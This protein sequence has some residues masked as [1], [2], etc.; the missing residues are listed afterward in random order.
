MWATGSGA[1]VTQRIAAPVLGGML[2]VLM[3]S[4]LVFPVLYSL[5]L[6]TQERRR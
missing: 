6:Q 4:L 3:L 2:S 1:D 5:V